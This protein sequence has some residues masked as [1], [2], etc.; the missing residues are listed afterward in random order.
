LKQTTSIFH[1]RRK[2]HGEED[3]RRVLLGND[4]GRPD[5]QAAADQVAVFWELDF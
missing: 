4:I 5:G 3:G 1:A 2:L